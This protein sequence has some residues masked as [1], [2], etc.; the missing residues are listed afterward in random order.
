MDLR[1]LYRIWDVGIQGQELQN[2]LEKLW[3]PQ[4]WSHT[5]I[6]HSVNLLPACTHSSLP[7]MGYA[8]IPSALISV[9]P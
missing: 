8:D 9:G 1:L 3:D 2:S 6:K 7:D 4:T 5:D